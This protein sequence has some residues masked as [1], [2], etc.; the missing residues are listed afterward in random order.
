MHVERPKN[1][2]L[3]RLSPPGFEALAPC[4]KAITLKAEDVVAHQGEPV[5]HLVFPTGALVSMI[6]TNSQGSVIETAMVGDE[7][8]VGLAEVM[9]SGIATVEMVT[10]VPGSAL[11]CAAAKGRALFASE[12]VLQDELWRT[13]EFQLAE[14][15]Q[16]T[17]CAAL[18]PADR[19][20]ARWLLE[21][22]DRTGGTTVLPLTQQFMAAM[23]SV[24]RTTVSLIASEMQAAGL[25]SYARGNVKI[26]E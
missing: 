11:I 6:A 17:L 26:L 22:S 16:S 10:Q 9:G 18:H 8:I 12:P 25:I 3:Q 14:A 23:L 13:I 19:R 2:L 21:S 5:D 4:L 15:R 24:Q 7:G 1:A 20:F